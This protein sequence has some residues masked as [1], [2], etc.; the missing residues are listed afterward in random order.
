MAQAG[1]EAGEFAFRGHTAQQGIEL[2]EREFPHFTDGHFFQ[3]VSFLDI[4]FELFFV[5]TMGRGLLPV[6][7]SL[8][9]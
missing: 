2:I 1:F 8:D 6:K 3:G 7:I 4:V 5:L 9:K